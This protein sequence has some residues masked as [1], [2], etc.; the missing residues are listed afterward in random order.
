MKALVTGG[1]GFIGSTL[2]RR[3]L[4]LGYEVIVIDN[5]SGNGRGES[6]WNWRAENHVFDLADSSNY[7]KLKD[8]MWSVDYVFHMA[9]DVSV[10]YCVE[11]P[12]KSYTNNMNCFVN[13]IG[14]ARE[15]NVRRFVFSSTSA[16][17]GLTDKVASENDVISPL[18]AYSYSKYAGECLAK[19]Y[20]ELYGLQTVC[21][22]YFNVYG[23]GQP[24][25]GQY[26]PVLGIF[27]KQLA[28]GQKLTIVGNG[29]QERDFVHVDDVVKANIAVATQDMDKYG[30]VYN[31][32]TGKSIS[33]IDL[34]RKISDNIEYVA[35]RDGEARYSCADITKIQ[36]DYDW[37]PQKTLDEWID[38]S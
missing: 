14:A 30:E 6:I 15:A 3:L 37:K 12:E 17:Y 22:R 26:A 2:V 11:E 8:L 4:K 23:P 33:I 19:M 21:L 5:E 32:G 24:S 1:A 28:S 13:V 18:N 38:E 35:P 29:L 7:E 34:A 36:S 25:K 31:V 9:A 16:V 27:E 10:Q 20:Y